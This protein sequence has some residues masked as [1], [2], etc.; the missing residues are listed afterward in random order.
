MMLIPLTVMA[1]IVVMAM[2][3]RPG[4]MGRDQRKGR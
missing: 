2:M 4:R 3:R 1:A